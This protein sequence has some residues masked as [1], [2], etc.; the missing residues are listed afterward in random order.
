M[1]CDIKTENI[2]NFNIKIEHLNSL[3]K[4]NGKVFTT[5]IIFL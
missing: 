3:Q 1:D 2:N 5:F 4:S